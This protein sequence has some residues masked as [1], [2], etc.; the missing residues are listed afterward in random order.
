[1]VNA[2]LH[3]F[4]DKKR[5]RDAIVRAERA[6]SAPI[7]VAVVP[8]VEGDVHAAALRALHARGLS[9]TP[10]RN[11]VHFF[12]VPS[13]REFAVVGDAGAHERLGQAAWDAVAAT[14]ER[15]FRRGDPTAG[16]ITG[17]EEIGALLARHFPRI[18]ETIRRE[19]M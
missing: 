15:H 12:V 18:S 11:A 3:R 16:L 1:V 8:H 6:T 2:K 19:Q 5:V 7:S 17:I 10:D 13:R 4:V 14:V 9:R